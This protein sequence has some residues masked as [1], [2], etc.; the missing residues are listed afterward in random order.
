M[1]FFFDK[2][3]TCVLLAWKMFSIFSQLFIDVITTA[4]SQSTFRNESQS[5]FNSSKYTTRPPAES[6]GGRNRGGFGGEGGGRAHV[7]QRV[8]GGGASHGTYGQQRGSDASN[9]R[10]GRNESFSHLRDSVSDGRGRGGHHET[11]SGGR[12]NSRNKRPPIP[13]VP[14]GAC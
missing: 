11:T 2:S 9:R 1:Q 5:T 3:F 10:G 4:P 13:R 7:D 8:G 6:H 12:D 14:V